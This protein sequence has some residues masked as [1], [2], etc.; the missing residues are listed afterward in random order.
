[1]RRGASAVADVT[2]LIE[3]DHREVESLFAQFK[4][5]GGEDVAETI[6]E[7]LEAHAAAEE[8]VFYPVVKS[9]VPGG[10][11]LAKEGNEEHGEARQLIGRIKQTTHEEHLAELVTELEQA[12]SHHVQEEESEMLPKT[13]N[14]L[15]PA[16]L[17]EIG[18]SFEAE[19]ARLKA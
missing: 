11:K 7:E 8:A 15:N 10:A 4:S 5:G 2:K 9:E 3:Q 19:K 18:A 17:D 12:V 1:M 13:R 6:C 14:A 16:R